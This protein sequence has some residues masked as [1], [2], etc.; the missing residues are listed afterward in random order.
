MKAQWISDHEWTRIQ[1]LLPIVCVDVL[2]VRFAPG[3]RQID[4]L[5]LILRETPHQG[6]RWCLVGGRMAY[7]ESLGEAIARH[8]F[9]TL[10]QN[11]QFQV[12]DDQ[13]PIFVAQYL[14]GARAGFPLDPRKH[15]VAL[16][17]CLEIGGSPVPQ[18]EAIAF[19]WFS[20]DRLPLPDEFGFEQ[21][22]VVDACL[23]RL[24]G[25]HAV[26]QRT[27]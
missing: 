25:Q 3:T 17:Y 13:Q 1:H 8:L 18:H 21:N 9:D 6:Q 5:G 26:R 12:R 14:P 7:D 11:I 2:S 19:D 15:A 27:E 4:A 20:P 16:T 24:M 10:G 22:L 23:E